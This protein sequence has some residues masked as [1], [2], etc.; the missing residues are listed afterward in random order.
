MGH[1]D[2]TS[3]AER[4]WRAFFICVILAGGSSPVWVMHI[5]YVIWVSQDI[6]T[7]ISKHDCSRLVAHLAREIHIHLLAQDYTLAVT[8]T[9]S[10][11]LLLYFLRL[12]LHRVHLTIFHYLHSTFFLI[13]F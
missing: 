8:S 3:S 11:L 2:W 5:P 13:I 6:D 12:F 4:L 1:N 7:N 9:V 10:D